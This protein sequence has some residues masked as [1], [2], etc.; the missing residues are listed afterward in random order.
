MRK[1]F[2]VLAVTLTVMSSPIQTM[3]VY[4]NNDIVQDN[5]ITEIQRTDVIVTKFRLYNGLVQYRRW[6]ETKGCWVDPDWINYE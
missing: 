5:R 6:N 1:S 3:W 4:K 2:V